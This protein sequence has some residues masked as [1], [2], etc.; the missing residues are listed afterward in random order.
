MSNPFLA[1]IRMFGGGFAPKGWALTNGQLLPISQ[2]TAL[3]ALLG[4]F[5]GGDGRSNFALPDLRGRMP[6]HGGQGPGLTARSLGSYGGVE[7][8]TQQ[9][10]QIPGSPVSPIQAAV[11]FQQQ[12][13]TISPFTV[14]TFI[15]ALQGIFPARS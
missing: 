14:V 15:I 5:Y 7:S 3:F 12:V 11:G 6:M 9:T 13:P 10:T 1:G 8:V 2:N 4:T